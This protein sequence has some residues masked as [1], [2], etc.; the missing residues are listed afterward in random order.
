M[1]HLISSIVPTPEPCA[2][3]ES[4]VPLL[5]GPWSDPCHS[6]WEGVPA[7]ANRRA[8]QTER[9]VWGT[10]GAGSAPTWLPQHVTGT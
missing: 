9:R 3:S 6:C 10:H 7:G 2:E 4:E 1:Y 8:S 5:E